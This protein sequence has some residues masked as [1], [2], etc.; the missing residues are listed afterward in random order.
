MTKLELYYQSKHPLWCSSKAPTLFTASGTYLIGHASWALSRTIHRI[1]YTLY[2]PRNIL[3]WGFALPGPRI[4]THEDTQPQHMDD[5]F[6]ATCH[7]PQHRP[8]A[9]IISYATNL[10]G[11]VSVKNFS[12]SLTSTVILSPNPDLFFVKTPLH[13][14][15]RKW[16]GLLRIIE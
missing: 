14:V 4:N 9:S 10:P 6:K 2:S 15:Q 5:Q 13:Y 7:P 3:A 12:R 11:Q 1:A 8:R 16:W